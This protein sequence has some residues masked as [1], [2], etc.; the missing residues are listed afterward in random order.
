[1][2]GDMDDRNEERALLQ[3]MVGCRVTA[4][5]WER[6]PPEQAWIQLFPPSIV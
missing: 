6:E 5:V 3:S 1:M 2:M 4:V